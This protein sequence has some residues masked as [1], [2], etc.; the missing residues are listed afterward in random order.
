[1]R[2]A[3][4]T[5]VVLLGLFGMHGL[6]AHGALAAPGA[7]PTSMHSMGSMQA[8]PA[9]LPQSSPTVGPTVGSAHP[10]MTMTSLCVAILLALT[11]LLASRSYAGLRRAAE[12]RGAAPSAASTRPRAPPNL[13]ALGLCR[14]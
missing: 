5:V 14:C 3:A 13:T 7:M 10:S 12:A 8:I 2:R 4:A 1:M 9:E 6:A 11:L